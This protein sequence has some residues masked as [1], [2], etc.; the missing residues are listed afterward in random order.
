MASKFLEGRELI[1]AVKAKFRE[2]YGLARSSA[3]WETLTHGREAN[4]GRQSAA[5]S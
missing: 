4:Q 5:A 1:D 2:V 3:L